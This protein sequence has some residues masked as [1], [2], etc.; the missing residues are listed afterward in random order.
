MSDELEVGL[1][2]LGLALLAVIV[3]P[4]IVLNELIHQDDSVIVRFGFGL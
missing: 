3:G 1:R 2:I 4:G